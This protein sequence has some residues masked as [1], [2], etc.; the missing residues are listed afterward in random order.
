MIDV[1]NVYLVIIFKS[2]NGG[3]YVFRVFCSDFCTYWH[4]QN[5]LHI[6]HNS[7]NQLLGQRFTKVKN[8]SDVE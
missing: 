7:V 6:V 2:L 3:M 5:S 4:D 1:Y 8:K